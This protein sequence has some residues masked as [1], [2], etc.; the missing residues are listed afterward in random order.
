M[1]CQ[2]AKQLERNSK[3]AVCKKQKKDTLQITCR[4]HIRKGST[5]RS[6]PEIFDAVFKISQALQCT[7]WTDSRQE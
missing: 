4:R 3:T 5:L 7:M 6:S 2:R 1:K